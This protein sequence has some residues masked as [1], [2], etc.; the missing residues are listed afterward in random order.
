MCRGAPSP[1]YKAK[2]FVTAQSLAP[3]VPTKGMS[4][5]S[6]HTQGSPKLAFLTC[7]HESPPIGVICIIAVLPG[8][9]S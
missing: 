6:D 2:S 7:V 8:T 1:L 9:I 4:S 3:R 5:Y